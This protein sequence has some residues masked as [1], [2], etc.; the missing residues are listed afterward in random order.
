MDVFS[1]MFVGLCVTLA[2]ILGYTF[3]ERFRQASPVLRTLPADSSFTHG[4][5]CFPTTNSEQSRTISQCSPRVKDPKTFSGEADCFK[6]WSFSV[7]LALRFHGITQGQSQV[8][9]AASYM[10]SEGSSSRSVVPLTS[11]RRGGRRVP[12]LASPPRSTARGD[13]RTSSRRRRP[14]SCLVL[15]VEDWIS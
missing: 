3:S 5:T 11:S 6:E 10:Y 14:S 7:D 8:N 15:T 4:R 13:V 9:F 2:F 1:F 12:R